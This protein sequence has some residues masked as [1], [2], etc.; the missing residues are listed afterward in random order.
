MPLPDMAQRQR[1]IPVECGCTPCKYNNNQSC[2]FSGRLKI[3]TNGE[4]TT[5]EVGYGGGPGPFGDD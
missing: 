4:C 5:K 2:N 1:R 3:N